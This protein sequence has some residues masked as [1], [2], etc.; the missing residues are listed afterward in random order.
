MATDLEVLN[1][2]QPLNTQLQTAPSGLQYWKPW[3]E[4]NRTTNLIDKEQRSNSEVP[5]PYTFLGLEILS[6]KITNTQPVVW[7]DM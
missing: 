5:K 2:T 6:M 7:L 3:S 1:L 4:A